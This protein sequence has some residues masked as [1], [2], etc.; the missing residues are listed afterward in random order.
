MLSKRKIIVVLVHGTWASDSAWT[1]DDSLL[2]KRINH[3][4]ESEVE[5][6][7]FRWS[8][9]NAH[10]A[11]IKAGKKL[12]RLISRLTKDGTSTVNLIA[13]SHG[14]NV[15]CYALRE[16]DFDISRVR[17]LT[18][19]TPFLSVHIRDTKLLVRVVVELVKFICIGLLVS[20]TLFFLFFLLH[21][22]FDRYHSPSQV[23]SLIGPVAFFSLGLAVI[24]TTMGLFRLNAEKHIESPIAAWVNRKQLSERQRLSLPNGVNSTLLSLQV[25]GDEARLSLSLA[26]RISYLPHVVL[27]WIK[28]LLLALGVVNLVLANTFVFFMHQTDLIGKM[29]IWTGCSTFGLIAIAWS[30]LAL[31][32]LGEFPARIAFGWWEILMPL[33]L[34]IRPVMVPEHW[35]SVVSKV[36]GLPKA[37]GLGNLRHCRIYNDSRNLDE[38]CNWL[39]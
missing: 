32:P 3:E 19:A 15:C 38:I 18:M 37:S 9:R 11:R 1:R 24:V 13:H 8:G 26:S 22:Y 29:M 34:E 17:I 27:Q 6:L 25:K 21:L 20:P 16:P 2:R 39:R 35:P 5:F 28:Y 7:R 33:L 23:G 10:N 36:S 30:F 4:F 12:G 14:G 31:A